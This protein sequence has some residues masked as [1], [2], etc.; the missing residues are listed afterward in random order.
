MF[1]FVDI[2]T[3]KRRSLRSNLPQG[4]NRVRPN[5]LA[6][7]LRLLQLAFKLLN[8]RI[9][10]GATIYAYFI[11][12][13]SE[14]HT[15]SIDLQLILYLLRWT[16]LQ[17]IWRSFLIFRFHRKCYIIIVDD[18]GCLVWF[19][20]NTVAV[21]NGHVV[22]FVFST[23]AVV[24]LPWFCL[25]VLHLVELRRLDI[26]HWNVDNFHLI[27]IFGSTAWLLCVCLLLLLNFLRD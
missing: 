23:W 26:L 7:C 15:V 17:R 8:W 16:F 14:D 21:V 20:F 22:W 4:L 25:L 10:V 9:A 3:D 6:W 13:W 18:R 27:G 19:M 11:F 5:F 24:W 1:L 12:P 2:S